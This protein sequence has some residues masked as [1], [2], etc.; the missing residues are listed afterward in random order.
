MITLL[1]TSDPYLKVSKNGEL[2]MLQDIAFLQK[3]KGIELVCNIEYCAMFAQPLPKGTPVMTFT[4]P[5]DMEGI[6]KRKS[7]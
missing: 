1:V 6:M 4:H 7:V 3:Y 2:V 5:D